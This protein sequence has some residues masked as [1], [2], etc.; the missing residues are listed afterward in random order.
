[1]CPCSDGALAVE[2][3]P[4]MFAA[5]DNEKR[6]MSQD[7]KQSLSVKGLTPFGS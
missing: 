5:K 2:P 3:R 6:M 7:L 1:M 4:S